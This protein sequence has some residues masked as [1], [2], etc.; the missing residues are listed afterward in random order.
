MAEAN[1]EIPDPIRVDLPIS[2]RLF[3]APAVAGSLGFFTGRVSSRGAL[4]TAQ[5]RN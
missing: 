3:I 4:S 1:H 5:T 2:L